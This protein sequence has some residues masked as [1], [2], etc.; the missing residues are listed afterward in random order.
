MGTGRRS[1]EQ[2]SQASGPMN[3]KARM[4]HCSSLLI[5]YENLVYSAH[6]AHQL[7]PENLAFA[8]FM[9]WYIASPMVPL[10]SPHFAHNW[11]SGERH[12]DIANQ[13]AM[14]P[15]SIL[16]LVPLYLVEVSSDKHLNLDRHR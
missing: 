13:T 11:R 14:A 1:D 2:L 3:K 6:C 12:D 8:H 10:A 7:E 16:N 9:P 15:L 5:D 4:Q